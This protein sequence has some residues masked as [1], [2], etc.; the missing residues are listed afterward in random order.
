[1]SDTR[2]ASLAE[3]RAMANAGQT[4]GVVPDAPERDMPDGFWDEAVAEAPRETTRV[5]LD[6]GADVLDHFRRGGAGY[7]ARMTAVL[8]AHVENERRKARSG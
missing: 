4:L 6:V 2:T 1:M 5:D 7:R 8:R 3:L